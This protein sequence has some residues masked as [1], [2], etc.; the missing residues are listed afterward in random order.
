MKQ[1][2]LLLAVISLLGTSSKGQDNTGKKFRDLH[3]YSNQTKWMTRSDKLQTAGWVCLG[4]GSVAVVIGLAIYQNNVNDS[5]WFGDL[6]A[7]PG[8]ICMGLGG[9]AI[10]TGGVLLGQSARYR[11][12][13]LKVSGFLR[14]EKFPTLQ[15]ST[16]SMHPVPALG[17]RVSF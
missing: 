15:G 4:T 5:G 7:M 14:Q 10:I 1:T 8:A 17:V 6:N 12:K 16:I 13:A 3:E 2:I 11:N 9:S